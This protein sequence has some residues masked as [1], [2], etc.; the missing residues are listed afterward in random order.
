MMILSGYTAVATA[1]TRVQVSNDTRRCR[2]IRFK[3]H[4]SNAGDLYIGDSSVSGSNGFSIDKSEEVEINFWE[5]G[6][7][8]AMNSFWVDAA[9][10]AEYVYW[11]AILDG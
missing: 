7:T 10:S 4:K 9:N 5:A 6:G 1:G 11:I 2:H 3:A 8:V